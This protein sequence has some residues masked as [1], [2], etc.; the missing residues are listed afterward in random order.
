MKLRIL[1][2]KASSLNIGKAGQ[3]ARSSVQ[4][5]YRTSIVSAMHKKLI[6]LFNTGKTLSCLGEKKRFLSFY[7]KQ[8]LIADVIIFK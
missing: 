7:F 1:K 8:S 2:F 3:K 4:S 6:T 5:L